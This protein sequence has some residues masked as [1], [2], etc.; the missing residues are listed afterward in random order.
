MNANDI[1]A[2]GTFGAQVCK[3]NGNERFTSVFYKHAHFIFHFIKELILLSL[4][5]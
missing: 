2:G 5:V 3:I 4:H 1:Q